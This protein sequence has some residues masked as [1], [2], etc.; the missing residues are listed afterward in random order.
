MNTMR[1]LN[2]RFKIVV[3]F[4]IMTAFKA[5][6]FIVFC[7]SEVDSFSTMRAYHSYC[8]LELIVS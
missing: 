5:L 6:K 4:L 8:M 2:R 3:L 7:S 1:S